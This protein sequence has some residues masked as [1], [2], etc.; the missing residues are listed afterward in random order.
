MGDEL[1]WFKVM[2]VVIRQDGIQLEPDNR[3]KPD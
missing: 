2:T 1:F 3:T